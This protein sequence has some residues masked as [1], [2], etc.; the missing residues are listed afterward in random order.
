MNL[1]SV[2]DCSEQSYSFLSDKL[3]LLF[4]VIVYR[5][6]WYNYVT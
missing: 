5:A 6:L 2:D 1:Y 3:Q 4:Y